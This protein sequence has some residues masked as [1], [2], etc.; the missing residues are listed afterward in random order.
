MLSI[1]VTVSMIEIVAVVLLVPLLLTLLSFVP[2]M[3]RVLD[4]GD[5]EDIGG[6]KNNWVTDP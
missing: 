4:P 5:N 1:L 6:R 2:S 3:S